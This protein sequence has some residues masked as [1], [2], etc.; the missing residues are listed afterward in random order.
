MGKILKYFLISIV[1]T[2]SFWTLVFADCAIPADGSDIN[3]SAELD[4]CLKD[5]PLVNGQNTKIWESWGFDKYI[6]NWV[7]N[8]WL[9]LWIFA[10]F[11]IVVGSLML[12]ISAWEDEKVN[13]AKWVI[14]WWI[15]WF[16]WV[17]SA[18]AIITIIV[19]LFYSI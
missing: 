2:F 9:Y 1:L 16:L 7:W 11:S 8:I 14:K 15:I 13:K 19:K 3:I 17:I 4:N 10:V 12:T 5:S 18:S 6:L